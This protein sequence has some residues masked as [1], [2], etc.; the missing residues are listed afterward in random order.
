M[1]KVGTIYIEDMELGLSRSISKVMG[2]AEIES[3]SDLSED[4]N[5]IHLSEDAG[6]ASIFKSRVAHGML[7][8][9]LFSALLGEYLPGHG[10]IYLSQS[11]QFT[12]P[13][14]PGDE[15]TASVTVINIDNVKNRITLKCEAKVGDKLVIKGEA[16]ALAP[17]RG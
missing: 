7:S 9:S 6:N 17:S 8:A 1:T 14:Y 10:A 16:L 2:D 13:V 11:L 15:V 3:F 12:Q 5:P 4:R